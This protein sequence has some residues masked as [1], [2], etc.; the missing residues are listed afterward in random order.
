MKLGLVTPGWT[1]EVMSKNIAMAGR[2]GYECLELDDID[3]FNI[4]GD[5]I[6]RI[7]EVVEE[8]NVS[9]ASVTACFSHLDP[10]PASKEAA[11]K[12]TVRA[13]ELAHK[14]GADTVMTLALADLT[15]TLEGNIKKYKETF[16]EY[17]RAAEANGVK[18]V[19]ENWPRMTR[20]PIRFGNL[21]F[22]PEMWDI[23]FNE[24]PS[25]AIGLEYDPSHLVWQG[26]D[27]PRT[28]K[29]FKDKIFAF[30]AKDTSIDYDNLGLVGIMGKNVNSEF[31]GD[32]WTHR[33]P[34][35]GDIKWHEVFRAL[36][37]IGYDG[38]VFLE[39]E[40]SAFGMGSDRFEEGCKFAYNFLKP[41]ILDMREFKNE[42]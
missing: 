15:D 27:I 2:L 8:N 42:K 12:A 40:D 6:K 7:L 4:D 34:G 33:L 41:Y 38:P 20:E 24:V 14:F 31:G 25:D 37:D 28:I 5:G 1:F 35:L 36:Y 16:S 39:Q 17:A 30:H 18:L 26:I 32:W 3:F 23:M 9:V 11:N 29:M 13:I 22:S 10:D 19:I 21:A